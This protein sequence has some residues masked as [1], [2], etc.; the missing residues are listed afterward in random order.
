VIAFDRARASVPA[1]AT[2]TDV[3]GGWDVMLGNVV[4]SADRTPECGAHGPMQ[5]DEAGEWRCAECG[6]RAVLVG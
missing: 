3:D 5:A 4:L 1:T 2:L 6:A